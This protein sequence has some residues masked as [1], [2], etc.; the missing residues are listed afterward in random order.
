MNRLIKILILLFLISCQQNE[1]D[2]ERIIKIGEK[3][4]QVE[5]NNA[6]ST[7]IT[8]VV[9]VGIGLRK[10]LTELRRNATEFEFKVQKED[11]EMP[12]ADKKADAIL[13]INSNYK[14]IGI[15]L[16]YD[17]SKDKYHILG[18]SALDNH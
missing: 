3:L 10:E 6:D 15:R 7:K 11:L 2:K 5:F 1:L 14:N 17:K 8:D 9:M 18:W 13:I 16:K 12:L 4:T